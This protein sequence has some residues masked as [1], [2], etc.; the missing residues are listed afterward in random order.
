[1]TAG[2]RWR[3]AL[4][5]LAVPE[6]VRQAAPDPNWTLEPQ[7]FRWKPEEDAK[8]PVRP[9][10][11]RALEALPEGGSVLD[12]GV[13]GGA[14]SLGLVP[15]AALI[16]GVDR[17]PDMLESFEES[18]RDM[19]VAVRSVLGTWPDVADQVEPADV[20]V[21]HHAVYGVG[22]I[23]EFVTALT[24]RA[25]RRVVLELSEHTPLAA[26]N[27]LWKTLH[28]I[29]RPDFRVAD[30]AHE[31][32]V[33]MGLAVE[34]EDVVLPPRAQEVTPETVAFARR[35]LYVGP[36]RDPEIEAFLRA[37]E[38]VEQRVVALWW[39]GAA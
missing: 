13:G 33:S 18:A 37:R 3:A 28:G 17:L 14:S 9:S 25:R 16:V 22:E 10:R 7:R 29:D 34:R 23:E 2:A 4:E 20:A 31:V 27:P 1:M 21:C 36:E 38:P 19:G 6:A 5:E 32:L 11:R 24:E 30:A 26:L 39:P 35:R 12:V 15:K 8:A